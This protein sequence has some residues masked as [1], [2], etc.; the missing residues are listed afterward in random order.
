MVSELYFP[1]EKGIKSA[2]KIMPKPDLVDNSQHI[3]NQRI[4]TES[5][6][7]HETAILLKLK[8][9]PKYGGPL[10]LNVMTST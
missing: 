4:C 8:G 5:C 2:P 6:L 9:P 3:Q 7:V 10:N 1:G